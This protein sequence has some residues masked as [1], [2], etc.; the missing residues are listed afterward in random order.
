MVFE[1]TM[2]M[3]I[4]YSSKEANISGYSHCCRDV[5]DSRPYQWT[6]LEY[7]HYTHIYIYVYLIALDLGN[8]EFTATPPVPAQHHKTRSNFLPFCIC[9]SLLQHQKPGFHYP[10]KIYFFDQSPSQ[11]SYFGSQLLLAQQGL[12]PHSRPPPCMD[13]LLTF[14]EVETVVQNYR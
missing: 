6:E 2:C 1:A 3:V 9:D 10:Y 4:C 5:T 11:I 13:G 7:T 14:L 8:Y 12:I